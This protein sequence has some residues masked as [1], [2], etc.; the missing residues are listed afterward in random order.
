MNKEIIN[1]Y[2]T[3]PM[4]VKNIRVDREFFIKSKVGNVYQDMLDSC[5]ERM[6]KE[7]YKI[8]QEMFS[9]YH[10]DIRYLGKENDVVRY[11]VN[12]EFIEYTSGELKEMTRQIMEQYL[13]GD[14]AEPFEVKNRIWPDKNY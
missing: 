2:I 3:L 9:Q 6:E 12:N 5:V 10:L 11:K 14:K 4:A 1:R 7:F 8:K 13:Y